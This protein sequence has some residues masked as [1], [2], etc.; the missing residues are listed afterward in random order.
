MYVKGRDEPK[1]GQDRPNPL[2][3]KKADN[4]IYN[5]DDHFSQRPDRGSQ[6]NEERACMQGLIGVG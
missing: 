4:S 1:T 2:R 3:C 6:M 5:D